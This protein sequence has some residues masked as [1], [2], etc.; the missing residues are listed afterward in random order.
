MI[1]RKL[2]P[3]IPAILWT[4]L[5]FGLSSV[6]VFASTIVKIKMIDKLAHAAEYGGLGLFLTVGFFGTLSAE[7]RRWVALLAI[8]TGLAIGALDEIYQFT[9]PG[10]VSDFGD[11]IADAIGVIIGTRIAI[12]FYRWRASER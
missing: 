11:W 6:S 9:V 5:I 4:A 1:L 12:E 10:R 7:N 2:K 3:W 8:L